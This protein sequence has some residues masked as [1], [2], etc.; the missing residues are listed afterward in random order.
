VIIGIEVCRLHDGRGRSQVADE[1]WV[2]GNRSRPSWWRGRCGSRSSVQ[3]GV[4]PL[5]LSMQ[6]ASRG[7]QATVVGAAIGR[8]ETVMYRRGKMDCIQGY[9]RKQSGWPSRWAYAMQ[10]GRREL[11]SVAAF[12]LAAV[13]VANARV[14]DHM[15]LPCAMQCS[16]PTEM[17]RGGGGF[18]GIQTHPS[19][20]A[21][22]GSKSAALEL[23]DAKLRPSSSSSSSML[24]ELVSSLSAKRRLAVSSSTAEPS[25]RFC[26]LRLRLAE[27]DFGSSLSRPLLTPLA[28][29]MAA[30][31][32][33]RYTPRLVAVRMRAVPRSEARCVW[34]RWRGCLVA[35]PV[36][37]LCHGRGWTQ[38]LQLKLSGMLDGVGAAQLQHAH[39]WRPGSTVN[40]GGG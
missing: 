29:M 39:L 26:L 28:S 37:T 11:T 3:T 36:Q 23:R 34:P 27:I 13:G 38:L 21:G 14:Q 4:R 10:D 31:R 20:V 33:R 7:S 12:G 15:E 5:T 2:R 35:P 19:G 22:C 1:R 32:S 25:A 30:C 40:R 9:R 6:A 17:A 8:T 18:K 16:H 24:V